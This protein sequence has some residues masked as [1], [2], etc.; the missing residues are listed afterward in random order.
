V[1]AQAQCARKGFLSIYLQS[2]KVVTAFI[3]D[4]RGQAVTEYVLI[5]SA[6]IIGT[7]ALSRQLLSKL[8]KG[9]LRLGGQLEKD[10]KSGRAPSNVWR[11]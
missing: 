4:G 6:C 5:L 3:Q 11:N 9:V 7:I 10:L 8:D 1:D 2:K